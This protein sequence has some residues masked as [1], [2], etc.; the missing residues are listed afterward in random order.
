MSLTLADSRTGV[1]RTVGAVRGRPVS[2]Y[3]CG[4]T[5]YDAT[6]V[7]HGRTYLYFDLI[8]RLL[9]EE[10]TPVRHVMNITDVEDKIA[11][12]AS[13]LGMPWRD[14]ARR[15]ERRFRSDLDGLGVLPPTRQPR[16]SA[17]VGRMVEVARRLERTGRV[18]RT[19]DGWVYAPDPRHADANFPIG[20]ELARHAVPEPGHPFEGP[21][22]GAA[23]F[24]TWKSQEPPLPSFPSP[25]G[26]GVPGWHLEC[27]T[28]A[29]GLLGLPVDL[30]G[31]G[32]DLV[33]PHHYAENEVALTLDRRPF[34]RTF[35]HTA[36]VTEDG[37]KMSKSLG[38]LVPLR[39]ALN[40]VGRDALR[41]Y[42]LGPPYTVKLDWDG[43]ALARAEA[44]WDR[45]QRTLT[46][47]VR[48]D[49]G[50]VPAARFEALATQVQGVLGDGLRAHD[51]LTALRTFAVDLDRS[52]RSRVERGGGPRARR[53]LRTVG[54]LLGL[55]LP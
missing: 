48:S 46:R 36:F 18:H 16:A 7:G 24:L 42:L 39:T 51:A 34:A 15:E 32:V 22:G 5:V 41:W 1:R 4:P 21:E 43:R 45:V 19:G 17:Y 10:G 23:S 53:A 50:A 29:R 55:S 26:R 8:R 14:L 49:G 25:W 6:H 54:R 3:V 9:R 30:H 2:L 47:A 28:M 20:A 52:P 44:D 27:Y 38:N 11:A 13:E 37:T 33:F 31:G 40:E 35:V 12:R